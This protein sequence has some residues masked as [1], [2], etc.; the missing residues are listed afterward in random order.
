MRKISTVREFNS[1]VAHA[2]H[3][4]LPAKLSCTVVSTNDNVAP[5]PDGK[6]APLSLRVVL[7]KH[8][9]AVI[10]HRAPVKLYMRLTPIIRYLDRTCFLS[11]VVESK[12]RVVDRA[13]AQVVEP[14]RARAKG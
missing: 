2:T 7:D 13:H 3:T 1:N 14:L 12:G 11:S 8:P 5:L 4:F 6:G 9:C 10:P